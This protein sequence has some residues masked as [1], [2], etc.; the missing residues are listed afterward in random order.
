LR[1]D[2]PRPRPFHWLWGVLA[3]VVGALIS[4]GR[5]PGG[6]GVLD[7]IWA[8]DGSDFL[9]DALNRNVFRTVVRPL[10]GYFVVVPRL[11]ALPASWA[12]IGWGPAVLTIEAALVTG[13]MALAV[14][15]ASRAYLRHPLAR[16]IAAVPVLAVPVGENIAAGT[17][18][19]VATLQFAATY[20]ALWLVLWLPPRRAT[21]IVAALAVLAVSF[22]TILSAVLIPLAVLRL[23]ARRDRISAF[24]AG[25]LLLG[26]AA[27]MTALALHLTGRPHMYPSK[28]D[29]GWAL[30]MVVEWALPHAMFGYGISG[31]GAQAV[32]PHWLVWFAWPIVVLAVAIAGLRL[33]RPHWRL[34]VI[35]LATGLVMVCATIMQFGALELRYV[36]AS[37]LMLFAGLAALLLPRGDLLRAWVP[38][39][40]LSVCVALVVAFSYRTAGPRTHLSSWTATVALARAACSG[41]GAGSVYLYPADGHVTA[42]PAGAA[43]H[44]HPPPSFP[45][46]IPCDRLR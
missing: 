16:L 22:T 14:Y 1:V 41:P 35:M 24:I 25:G 39:A 31:K 36:V 7:T 8:E 9:T 4:L 42:M 10:N 34:A 21:Q 43:L 20:T 44:R 28:Y 27:N 29:P 32:D 38:L 33:T 11:L 23:Y 6:P 45:V 18:N 12:P 26:L 13:L 17:S 15:A 30:S 46:L 19:N 3:V 2:V 5:V 40:T 37:E